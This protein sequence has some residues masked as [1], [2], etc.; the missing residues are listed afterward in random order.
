MSLFG[1][2]EIR[3]VAEYE[4]LLSVI[5]LPSSDVQLR[6]TVFFPLAFLPVVSRVKL[7]FSS[8]YLGIL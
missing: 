5:G 2:V 3:K 7:V 1:T 6:R 8:V 4:R